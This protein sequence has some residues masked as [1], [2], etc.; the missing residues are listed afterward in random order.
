M[1]EKES[2]DCFKN[3]YSGHTYDDKFLSWEGRDCLYQKPIAMHF[4]ILMRCVHENK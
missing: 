1:N 2:D 4:S 3:E